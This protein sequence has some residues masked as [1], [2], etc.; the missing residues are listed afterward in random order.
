MYK[1][2]LKHSLQNRNFK[3]DNKAQPLRSVYKLPYSISSDTMFQH[4]TLQS[5][6][7]AKNKHTHFHKSFMIFSCLK[8]H[9]PPTT[10][11]SVT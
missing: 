5:L 11:C 8:L 9:I 7:P 4:D 10:L 3:S 6:I 2:L 1:I